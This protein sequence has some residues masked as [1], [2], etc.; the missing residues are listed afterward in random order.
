[1]YREEKLN[2][3]PGLTREPCR[4]SEDASAAMSLAYEH[5]LNRIAIKL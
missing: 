2:K 1:M 4:Q 5:W 3:L